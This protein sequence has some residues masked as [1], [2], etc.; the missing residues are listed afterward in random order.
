MIRLSP[1]LVLLILLTSGATVAQQSTAV[2]GQVFEVGGSTPVSGARVTL[3]P[4]VDSVVS[5]DK[6]TS[7]ITDDNG[8]YRFEQL[9]V[10]SYRLTIARIGFKPVTIVLN[11][12]REAPLRM[13]VGMVVHPVEL[14]RVDVTAEESAA[15]PV[16]AEQERR[17][18]SSRRDLIARA[19]IE[20]RGLSATNVYEIVRRLRPGWL[21][22]RGIPSTRGTDGILVYVDN[23]RYGTIDMLQ[24]M[25]VSTIEEIWFIDAL[26]ATQRWGTG[27][28]HGVIHVL[29]RP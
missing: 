5:E 21:S 9:P 6:E 28:P 2:Q 11:L 22:S 27:H 4:V 12:Q 19:E 23:V 18:R 1:A 20:E 15:P 7:A 29:R 10:G 14:E 25:S 13:A 8:L 3:I 26:R 24:S 17:G 16:A